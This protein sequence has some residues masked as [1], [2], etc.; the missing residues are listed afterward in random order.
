MTASM[1]HPR[2]PDREPSRRYVFFSHDGYG[3]GHVRRNALI[4]DEIL[5]QDPEADITLVTGVRRLPAWAVDPRI[6]VVLIPPLVKGP[7]GLYGNDTLSFEETVIRRSQVFAGV[8]ARVEPHVVVVDRHPFGIGGELR[9]ALLAQRERGTTLV[10]GLRDILDDPSTVKREMA[11]AGWDDVGA[12]FDEIL[13][14]GAADFCDHQL[15]YGLPFDRP[16]YCGWVVETPPAARRRDRF[17]TVAA[18]GGGDGD[19]VFRLGV[20]VLEAR[21]RWRGV[22]A[23]G[24]Y[25]DVQDLATV[26]A[27]SPASGRARLV[28]D[29]AG[30]PELFARSAAAIQMAGY[31]ST[32]EAL[33]AGLRPILVPRCQP[34]REQLIRAERLA[35]RGLADVVTEADGPDAVARLLEGNRTQSQRSVR[36]AGVDLDGAVAAAARLQD[37]CRTARA[38]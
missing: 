27:A 21:P 29:A 5:S 12:I 34:R 11:G 9:S 15:E 23:A 20:A 2:R 35:E 7:A 19:R 6:S 10:L 32:F 17:V 1:G 22:L 28:E 33:A 37:R 16:T 13:V 26:V 24:P 38:A 14:Y 31:N 18:G 8:L 36:A 25:A 3:V 4:A 30:C